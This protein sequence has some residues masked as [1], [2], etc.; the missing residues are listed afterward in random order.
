MVFAPEP[1]T[2]FLSN[3]CTPVL[4]GVFD[5]RCWADPSC[6]RLFHNLCKVNHAN[7]LKIQFITT[8]LKCTE[9][10]PTIGMITGHNRLHGMTLP[11][12]RF[13]GLDLNPCKACWRTWKPAMSKGEVGNCCA[14]SFIQHVAIF[15]QSS[16]KTCDS[17][18]ETGRLLNILP[19]SNIL[20]RASGGG[21]RSVLLEP[22]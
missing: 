1:P 22:S 10:R 20:V 5:L 19:S 8:T 13:T 17:Q 12:I 7:V 21:K 3:T 4:T 11:R 14:G 18:K 2:C 9:P 16:P 6:F 15:L